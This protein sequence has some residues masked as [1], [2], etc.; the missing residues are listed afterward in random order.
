MPKTKPQASSESTATATSGAGVVSTTSSWRS[1]NQS[2]LRA[3]MTFYNGV[4][5]RDNE[6]SLGQK[7]VIAVTF[8]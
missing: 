5:H 7:E 1:L 6:L 8:S 4:M 3:L 2:A